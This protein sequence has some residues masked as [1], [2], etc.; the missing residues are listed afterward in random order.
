MPEIDRETRMKNRYCLNFLRLN[1]PPE[2]TL[3]GRYPLIPPSPP[4]CFFVL[5]Q[6]SL[7][8]QSSD[9]TRVLALGGQYS[10]LDPHRSVLALDSQRSHL[11]QGS[12]RPHYSIVHV[13][14]D[15]HGCWP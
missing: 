10:H 11:D 8:M 14:L 4:P 13:S 7:P 1:V 12:Y 15:P 3:Q 2:S 9:H 5:T 6:G